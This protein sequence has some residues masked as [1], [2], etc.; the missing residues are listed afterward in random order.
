MSRRNGPAMSRNKVWPQVLCQRSIHSTRP[1]ATPKTPSNQMNFAMGY[2]LSCFGHTSI[3]RP[4]TRKDIPK[5]CKI[6]ST[7]P[8]R[9]GMFGAQNVVGSLLFVLWASTVGFLSIGLNRKP[10][11]DGQCPVGPRGRRESARIGMSLRNARYAELGGAKDAYR[12]RCGESMKLARPAGFEPTSF[13]FGGLHSIH[14]SYGRCVRQCIN[15]RRMSCKNK[16]RNR[17]PTER[18]VRILVS[19]PRR[20]LRGRRSYRGADPSVPRGRR[21]VATWCFAAAVCSVPCAS[22]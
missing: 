3:S 4:G 16:T 6:I 11:F 15:K 9:D 2:S 14:L 1:W 18:R 12:W 22:V 17:A 8:P 5:N 13:G 10:S 21:G 7:L 20:L 19:R